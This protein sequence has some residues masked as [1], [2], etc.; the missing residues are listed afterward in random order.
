MDKISIRRAK[1]AIP[2]L[3]QLATYIKQNKP[4]IVTVIEIGSYVGDSTAVWAKHFNEVIA[5]DPWE[6]GY[7]END[8]S[9][10][11]YPMSLV[12]KQF[13]EMATTYSN[14]VKWKMS[15]FEAARKFDENTVQ[16]VYI[17]ALHTFDGVKND[18]EL[19]YP[20][21]MKGFYIGG[22][23]YGSKHHPGVKMAVDTMFGKPDVTFPDSSWLKRKI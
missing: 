21:I 7:D 3:I 1:N 16:F 2:G 4:N 6:N 5:V 15:S 19:W 22:H 11:K 8:A 17:D 10:W 20:K 9:S 18:I 12:E 23:D 13:D 14:I